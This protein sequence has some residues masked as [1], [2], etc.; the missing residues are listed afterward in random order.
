MGWAAI[1]VFVDDFM[2]MCQDKSRLEHLSRLVMHAVE[3]VFPAPD[4][5]GHVGGKHPVSEK[6]LKKGEADWHTA[7]EV[8]GWLLDSE[9]R[10]V[11]LSPD[12]KHRRTPRKSAR[13]CAQ[14]QPP[15]PVKA[16]PGTCG[17]LWFAALCLPTGKSFMIP[18]NMALRG[19][20]PYWSW[21]E[22]GGLRSSGGLAPAD[23]G[24][25]KATNAHRGN[26]PQNG[27][28]LRLL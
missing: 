14:V 23:Q 12:K 22:V 6:K 5:T 19:L 7:K 1:E 27:S 9:S 16:I 21:E 25:S 2:V 17:K 24:P 28:L 10:T 3:Q 4:I 15:R 18:L 26:L 8:L 11:T 20:P 13:S